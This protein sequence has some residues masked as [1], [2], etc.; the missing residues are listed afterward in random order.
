[1]TQATP[2]PR[3]FNPIL[4][5]ILGAIFWFEALL[6]IRF[7][8]TSLFVKGNPLL[9]LLFGASI[10]ISWCLVKVS[11]IVTKVSDDDRL[12]AV[13]IM[14]ITAAS[15]DGIALT[16]FPDWYG[17]SPAGLLLAA[18]WLLWGVGLSLAMGYRIAVK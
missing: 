16:W 13:A 2:Q 14:V 1:M 15:L 12:N 6:F 5:A 17:L 8:G 18:A 7:E 4:F 10:P 9:W 3:S 11:A